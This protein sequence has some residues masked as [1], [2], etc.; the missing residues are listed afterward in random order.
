MIEFL[1]AIIC[2]TVEFL[3]MITICF[4]VIAVCGWGFIFVNYLLDLSLLE[5][6]LPVTW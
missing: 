5:K 2:Y 6:G 3:L 4:F 1:K